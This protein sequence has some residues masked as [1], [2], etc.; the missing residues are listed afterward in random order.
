[1]YSRIL[2]TPFLRNLNYSGK[3]ATRGLKFTPQV[4][5]V[6][7]TAVRKANY[8]TSP[9]AQLKDVLKQELKISNSIPNELDSTYS[10]FLEKSGF[11]VLETEGKSN[12]QLVK[13]VDNEVIRVFFDVDEVTD[14]P[15]SD[16]ASEEADIEDEIESLDS[17]LCN[18]RVVI[19]NPSTDTGLLTNLFLQSSES[20]FLVDFVNLQP[21]VSKFLSELVLQKN[22]FTDKFK[23]QGPRFSDL[24]ESVQTSFESYLESKGISDELAEFV[25]AYSEF[26]EEKEYRRWLDEL[27]NFLN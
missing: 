4:F 22:E 11:E 27:A 18:V 12:V 21:N 24:D 19:E 2:K 25:I 1:M 9:S 3:A 10:E 14:V 13:K 20:S 23:Y 6:T 16:P 17:L 5:K 15:I 8:S 26:K 7:P